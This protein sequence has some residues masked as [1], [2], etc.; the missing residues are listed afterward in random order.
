MDVALHDI[1]AGVAEKT[2]FFCIGQQECA[3]GR[4]VRIMA[5]RTAAGCQRTMEFFYIRRQRMTVEAEFLLGH[6]QAV[7]T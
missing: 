3:V 6:D 1:F 2:E 5:D 7:R 4:A